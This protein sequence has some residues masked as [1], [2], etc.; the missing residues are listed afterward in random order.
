MEYY[1]ELYHYGTPRHSGRYPYGSGERPY[2]S[3]E[4][5][6]I[7]KGISEKKK[8]AKE[9]VGKD[10]ST[11]DARTRNRS[12]SDEPITIS[13]NKTIQH[14]TGIPFERIKAGQLYASATELD[15][16]LYETFLGMRLKSK[17]WDPKKS[18]VDVER[19]FKSAVRESSN[20]HFFGYGKRK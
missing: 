5:S 6:K 10:I 17:G 13:K 11:Q 15:N 18:Y 20:E 19:R 7:Q 9:V 12:I 14:I 4:R 2:Q 8:L 3:E 1:M 16:K